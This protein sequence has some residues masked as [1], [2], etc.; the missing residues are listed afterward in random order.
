MEPKKKKPKF[1]VAL[2]TQQQLQKNNIW[3]KAVLIFLEFL[4]EFKKLGH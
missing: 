1:E 2:K 3:F 4:F